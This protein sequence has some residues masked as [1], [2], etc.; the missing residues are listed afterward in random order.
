MFDKYAYLLYDYAAKNKRLVQSVL[1]LLIIISLACLFFVKYESNMMEHML[2]KNKVISRSMEFFRNSN[3]AG[4]VIVSL[5]LTAPEK[6]ENDLLRE[7]D[8]LADSLDKSLFPQVTVGISEAAFAKDID[9]MFKNLPEMISEKELSQIDSW[10]NQ[11]YI[12][13]KL[14]GAYLQLLKPQGILLGS[15]LRSDPLGLRLLVL[16]KLKSLSSSTG[17]DVEIKDG[18]FVS[19]DRRHAMLIAKTVIPITDTEGGKRMIASL[20]KSLK[21][22]PGYIRADI[23]CGHAHTVSNEKLIK[24][25]ITFISIVAA[26]V[27]ILLYVFVI[28]DFSAVLIFLTPV[29]AI[30][31]S[32]NLSY[33]FLGNLSYW[34]IGLGSTVAG[35]TI[36]YGTHVYF[37]AR[38]KDDPAPFVKHVIKPVS[39]GAFTTIAIFIA[40]FFSGIKGYNQLAVFTIISIIL[41]T[42]ISIFVLPHI[43]MKT[44]N[45]SS[46]TDR[47]A[48][49]LENRNLSSGLI[50]L[51]WLFLTLVLAYFSVYVGFEKDIKKIDGTEKDI[52]QA[53]ERFQKTWGGEKTPAVLVVNSKDYEDALEI[54]EKIYKEG[55]QAIGAEHF[56]SM[57][58][59]WQSKKTRKENFER[60]KNF[61]TEERKQKLRKLLLQEGKKYNFSKK[62]FDPFFISLKEYSGN[63]PFNNTPLPP[64]DRG[65]TH[66]PLKKGDVGG[67]S[68]EITGRPD[69]N[70]FE[71]FIQKT[72]DDYMLMSFFPDTKEYVDSMNKISSRY[73]DTYMVSAAVLSNTLSE[74]VS[75]DLKLMT[76]IA[77]ISVIALTYLCFFNFRETLI[78][79]VPPL[80]S[81]V[82]LFGLMS[83]FGLSINAANMIAGVLAIG[84]ASDYGIFMTYRSRGEMKTGTVLAIILCTVTTLI[85]AGVL[86]FAKHPALSSVGI[87]MVIGVSAGF[88]SSVFVVPKLAALF[89]GRTNKE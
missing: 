72:N 29:A 19:R 67:F 17:Y 34:V 7:I 31:F 14:H 71:R 6:N 25:D 86:I 51:L 40:F 11:D 41:S 61:W 9:V 1:L 70:L 43:I 60:W 84:L 4:K 10:I 32:I 33:F 80:T 2:P 69:I 54:N 30:L 63:D 81:I 77:A 45:G 23:I 8:L 46:F 21:T 35:I 3:I 79:L 39:F 53:E 75:K 74:V 87:T 50:I 68:D 57:A 83:L 36:D 48:E 13:Q 38:G 64:L 5:E 65:E 20:K 56:T 85:G 22:L 73:P 82:W 88:F 89:A 16:E 78:A 52:I 42:I 28:R 47:T 27:L 15:I 66:H 12:S 58:S 44:G 26:V 55:V 62:A 49:R 18:H 59:L 24:R 37:A 76:W